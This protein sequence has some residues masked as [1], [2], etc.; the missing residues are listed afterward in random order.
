MAIPSKCSGV[1]SVAPY[2]IS[3]DTLKFEKKKF[4][5]LALGVT[6]SF[7]PINKL[8]LEQGRFIHDLDEYMFFCVLGQ[9]FAKKL[10]AL[11]ARK[12]VGQRV[13]FKEKYFT[14]VGVLNEA[15][16][17]GMRPY[18]INPGIM[19][20][21]ST[22]QRIFPD[23]KIQNIMA[24]TASAKHNSLAGRQVKNYFQT[25][26]KLGVDVR[27]AEELIAQMQKQMRLYTLLL[28]A[29]GSIS[30]IVGGI[31]VMNVML[32]SVSERTRE[33]GIRR[34]LGARQGDIQLQFLIESVILCI[35]GG[36]IGIGIGVG[37]SWIISYYAK[38]QFA[39]SYESIMLGVAV[40][41]TVGIFFGFYPARQAAKL[42][43]IM[44]L[45]SN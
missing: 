1:K 44:A 31:G 22:L 11:G 32:V 29:I 4:S 12:L 25:L 5:V 43:P 27:N 36:M 7:L 16:M 38:W 34:A 28:G 42:S 13:L 40:S 33:I 26:Y 14:V 24:R 3:Y 41:V 45:R 20:P 37:A 17:G 39:V 30:L 10:K 21:V 35:I 6:N 23:S 18:E 19:M 8:T 15:A 2:A 9:G